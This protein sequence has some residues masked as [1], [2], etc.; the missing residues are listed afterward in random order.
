M[1]GTHSCTHAFEFSKQALVWKKSINGVHYFE[2]ES[3]FPYRDP[4]GNLIEISNY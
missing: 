4:D 2:R 1:Q 3:T